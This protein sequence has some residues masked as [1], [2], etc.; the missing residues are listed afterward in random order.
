MALTGGL[1]ARSASAACPS[2][3]DAASCSV[4]SLD[5][6]YDLSCDLVPGT[7]SV[8]GVLT[9]RT[10]PSGGGY[11]FEAYGNDA[12]SSTD[13]ESTLSTYTCPL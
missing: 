7:D 5:G 4:C 6:S 8:G 3:Y 11:V 12:S 13:C 10:V 2:P 1:T 9:V